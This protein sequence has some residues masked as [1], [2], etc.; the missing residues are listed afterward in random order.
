MYKYTGSSNECRRHI[1]WVLQQALKSRE[2]GVSFAVYW[3]KLFYIHVAHKVAH[4]QTL[5][6][7]FLLRRICI[8]KTDWIKLC[9]K[10]TQRVCGGS[11]IDQHISR[12]AVSSTH[13]PSH[14]VIRREFFPVLKRLRREADNS[15][16]STFQI[17]ST[18]SY[19]STTR[20]P[21]ERGA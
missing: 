12:T 19:T 11:Y 8:S 9:K 15:L 13:S 20:T 16:L 18:W 1:G 2:N 3:N 17:K 6:L 4:I 5:Q 14:I 10:M 21:A 7:Q